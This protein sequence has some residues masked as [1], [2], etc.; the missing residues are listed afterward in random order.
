M[1]ITPTSLPYADM[2]PEDMVEMSFDGTYRGA[3]RPSSEWRFHR[4]IIKTRPDINVVL[5]T[6]SIYSSTLSTL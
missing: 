4:D 2:R 3:R 5:H 6:H 1:L